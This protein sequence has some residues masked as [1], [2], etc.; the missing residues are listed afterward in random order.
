MQTELTSRE[1]EANIARKT[2]EMDQQTKNCNYVEAE[3][4]RIALD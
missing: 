1:I 2:A 4:C 3:N